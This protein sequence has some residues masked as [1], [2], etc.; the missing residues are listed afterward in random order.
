MSKNK[1]NNAVDD[2]IKKAKSTLGTSNKPKTRSQNN[3]THDSELASTTINKGNSMEVDALLEVGDT[4]KEFY[5]DSVV[6]SNQISGENR[7][8]KSLV[9]Q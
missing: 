1:K 6:A 7:V 4:P 3:V 5:G 2:L 9:E 8:T